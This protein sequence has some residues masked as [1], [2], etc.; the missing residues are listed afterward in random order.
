[1]PK[2]DKYEI[3]KSW[4]PETIDAYYQRIGRFIDTHDYFEGEEKE[5]PNVTIVVTHALALDVMR[6]L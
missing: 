6:K 3:A 2:Q 4:Y 1:M 5:G